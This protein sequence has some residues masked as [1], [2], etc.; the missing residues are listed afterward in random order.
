MYSSIN[1][2]CLRSI[3]SNEVIYNLLNIG[4]T[5]IISFTPTHNKEINKKFFY[6]NLLGHSSQQYS[7]CP[8][9]GCNE[10]IQKV[11]KFFTINYDYLFWSY[12]DFN[13]AFFISENNNYFNKKI[14]TLSR[15]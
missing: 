5:H 12:T 7:E 14:L 8:S 1:N 9:N 13:N 15:G 6:L 2:V 4:I 10:Y 3:N 11:K